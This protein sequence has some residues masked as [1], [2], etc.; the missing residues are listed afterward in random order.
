VSAKA[1]AEDK[2]D[3]EESVRNQARE[4]HQQNVQDLMN[5]VLTRRMQQESSIIPGIEQPQSE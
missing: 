4:V 5:D 3:E 2:L 1:I